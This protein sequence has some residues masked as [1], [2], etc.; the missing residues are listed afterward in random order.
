M[1]CWLEIP[2]NSKDAQFKGV[3]WGREAVVSKIPRC[4]SKQPL[5]V[6]IDHVKED[7]I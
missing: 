2:V 3:I 1:L 5:S 7:C 4:I 6:N